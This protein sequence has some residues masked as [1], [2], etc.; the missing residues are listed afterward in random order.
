ME[1]TYY[2]LSLPSK[3]IYILIEINEAREKVELIFFIGLIPRILTRKRQIDLKFSRKPPNLLVKQ[4]SKFQQKKIENRNHWIKYSMEV[5]SQQLFQMETVN[6]VFLVF[7][8]TTLSIF[9]VTILK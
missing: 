2:V 5:Q 1:L 9:H 6:T 8:K 7:R 3:L 4:L